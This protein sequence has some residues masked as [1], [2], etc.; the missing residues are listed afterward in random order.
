MAAGNMAVPHLEDIRRN[1]KKSAMLQSDLKVYIY[2]PVLLKIFFKTVS[3]VQQYSFLK[4]CRHHE[5][6][7]S[8]TYSL[9]VPRQ[10][11]AAVGEA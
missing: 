9:G 8:L 1:F 11:S 10:R 5:N 3:K 7:V 2:I 6:D 4:F